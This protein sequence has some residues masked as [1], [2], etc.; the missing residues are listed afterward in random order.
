LVT[1]AEIGGIKEKIRR[2]GEQ[3]EKSIDLDALI[4]IA[5]SACTL[6]GS[7][8]E[9]KSICPT[10]SG[11]AGAKHPCIAVAMDRAFCFYYAD[12]LNLLEQLG[13]EFVP[14][15]P[16]NDSGLP[17]ETSAVYLG[18]G[19][20]ELYARTLSDNT[21]MLAAIRSADESGMPILAECRGFLYL[22]K[23]LE[24]DNGEKYP[25]AGVF[26]ANGV[27]TP[28]L[29]R[30]GYIRLTAEK[31]TLLCSK[32]DTIPAHEFHYW[33]SSQTGTACTAKKPDVR[34]WPCVI[35]NRSVFAGFPHLYFYG[36]PAFA[37]RFVQAATE[38]GSK[39]GW[40]T[41]WQSRL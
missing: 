7:L 30:F 14:F 26:D 9:I 12:N 27:K 24:D 1:A 22:H 28:K 16:L 35:S 39:V 6:E 21:A 5:S 17:P 33:D 10:G 8:P 19:Y 29:Q 15:S 23:T 32:G 11:H 20:P 36:N 37:E 38:Y 31:D 41:E 4:Y 40:N 13:A 34:S 2:L 18:G 3:A 25:M